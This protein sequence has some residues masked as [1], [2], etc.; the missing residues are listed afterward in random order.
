MLPCMQKLTW[1]WWT[2]WY[3][4]K[5]SQNVESQRPPLPLRQPSYPVHAISWPLN[6]TSW[7]APV[8]SSHISRQWMDP[9]ISKP[10]GKQWEPLS[11]KECQPACRKVL[12]IPE[13]S[14]Y[15]HSTLVHWKCWME[16]RW[17]FRPSRYQSSHPSMFQSHQEPTLMIRPVYFQQ[18]EGH[19]RVL[20]MLVQGRVR[21]SAGSG[22]LFRTGSLGRFPRRRWWL[23]SRS[24]HRASCRRIALLL[25]CCG[26]LCLMGQ[27]MLLEVRCNAMPEHIHLVLQR[28]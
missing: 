3:P 8:P 21:R 22:G 18:W 5:K 2:L 27:S 11:S 1:V 9:R 24:S 14:L 23:L 6:L 10:V 16:N 28:C 13:S 20:D 17:P 12:P 7:L 25:S 19:R 26:T 4:L 15:F